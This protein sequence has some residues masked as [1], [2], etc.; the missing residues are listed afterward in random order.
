MG[1]KWHA[2]AALGMAY[3]VAAAVADGDKGLSFA[4]TIAGPEEASSPRKLASLYGTTYHHVWPPMKFG[5]RIV[6]GSFI[7]F[8]GAAFGSV[9]GV[10]GGGI[11]VPM[12]TLI[13][14]FDPKSSAAMSKCMI[15]GAAVSTV[16]CNLKLKHPTLDMPMIDYDLALLIQPMLMMGV[17]IGVICNVI[18]PDWLVTVLLIILFL[19]TSVKAFLKGVE[20]WK[21]ETVIRRV[22]RQRQNN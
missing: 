22:W 14:G 13:I 7:G 5:W 1:R 2:V 9:G 20:A 12:L 11:F 19:V 17:S 6:L 3:A 8:F 4:G 10:G 18:F 21:K 15:T 16:Y